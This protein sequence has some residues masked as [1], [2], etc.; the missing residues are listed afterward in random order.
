M[1]SMRT[2]KAVL[3]G[4]VQDLP[5]E[6]RMKAATL[7]QAEGHLLDHDPDAA[8]KRV[9]CYFD[10]KFYADRSQGAGGGRQN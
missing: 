8:G 2:N 3:S 4:L 10:E 7:S 5:V 6:L 9:L 1:V